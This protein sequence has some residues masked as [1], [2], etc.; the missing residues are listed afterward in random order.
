MD[1][2]EFDKALIQAAFA[3]AERTGW[4]GMSVAAAATEAGLPLAQARARLPNRLA[5]LMRFGTIADQEALAGITPD[6]SARDRLFD[7]IMRRIDVLQAHRGGVLAL[8]GYL[9]T[10]PGLALLLGLAT[11]RSMRWMLEAAGLSA[12]GLRGELR[13]KGLVAVWLWVVRAWRGDDSPDLSA[14]MA[15][16]DS[17]LNRA[18]QAEGW[19]PGG[20][21]AAAVAEDVA[22]EEAAEGVVDLPVDLP[23]DLPSAPEPAPDLPA[24]PLDS[25]PEPPPSPPSV[26]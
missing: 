5:V 13:A 16:L 3:R 15:A 7:L 24:A 18:E 2:T 17:A 25:P 11:Q 19:L 4:G 22:E 23:P 10:D 6:G 20:N 9:P 26:L 21:S 1:D 12:T 8:L 14:T